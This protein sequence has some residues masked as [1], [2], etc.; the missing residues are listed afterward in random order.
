MAADAR[1]RR[2]VARCAEEGKGD[3]Q[4]PLAGQQAPAPGENLVQVLAHRALERVLEGHDAGRRPPVLH[5]PDHVR[6]RP[7][8]DELVRRPGDVERRLVRERALWPE[9]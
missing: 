4:D 6:R 7:Q 9:V 2:V 1:Q 8:R 5:R 3:C